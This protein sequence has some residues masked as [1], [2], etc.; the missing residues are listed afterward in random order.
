[1]VTI[2]NVKKSRSSSAVCIDDLDTHFSQYMS[3]AL[4]RKDVTHCSSGNPASPN[5][6]RHPDL[7]SDPVGVVQSNNY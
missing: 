3:D 2:N 4:H 5:L 7:Q 6:G 1:M